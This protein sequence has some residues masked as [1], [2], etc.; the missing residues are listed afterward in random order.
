MAAASLTASTVV[1]DLTH[2]VDVSSL[3]TSGITVV[4]DQLRPRP[5]LA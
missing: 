5:A 4:G 1:P 3:G 2:A